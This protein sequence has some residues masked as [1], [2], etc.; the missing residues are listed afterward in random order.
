MIIIKN[1]YRFDIYLDK[2]ILKSKVYLSYQFG[3]IASMIVPAGSLPKQDEAAAQGGN[4]G[5][6]FAIG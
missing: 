1:F 2:L 3:Q 6:L 4:I 5:R